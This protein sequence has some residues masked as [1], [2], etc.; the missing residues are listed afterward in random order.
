MRNKINNKK[1]QFFIIIVLLLF[2]ACSRK[3]VR[4]DQSELKWL[5]PFNKTDSIVYQSEN[6]LRDTIIFFGQQSSSS[7]VNN[8]E[9]GFY[10]TYS[11][12]V[13]YELTYNSYHKFIKINSIGEQ[14]NGNDESRDLLS[15]N[16]SNNTT[17]TA[18][19]FYFLGL[20]FN[21]DFLGSIRTDSIRTLK[22]DETNAVYKELN[23]KEGIKNFEF[24]FNKGI[25][26]FIDHNGI[27]WERPDSLLR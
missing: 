1:T 14:V 15:I 6:G 7:S 25:V 22:L 23:I 9:Q 8:M 11:M 24:D 2:S 26:S 13:K 12:N 21:Q 10:N 27:K 4:F 3:K 17:G 16:K 5:Q 18:M 20:L 19:E